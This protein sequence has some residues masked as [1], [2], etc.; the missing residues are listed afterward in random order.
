MAIS[1]LDRWKRDH[2]GRGGAALSGSTIAA[3]LPPK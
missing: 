2:Q 1:I 3:L